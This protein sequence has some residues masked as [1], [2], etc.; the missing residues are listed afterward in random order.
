MWWRLLPNTA[1]IGF[2]SDAPEVM[3]MKELSRPDLLGRDEPDPLERLH[4]IARDALARVNQDEVDREV[5]DA[6]VLFG[7]K[8]RE[9]PPS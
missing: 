1:G 2:R 3:T 4:A 9:L 5:E 7:F 6:R 8:R